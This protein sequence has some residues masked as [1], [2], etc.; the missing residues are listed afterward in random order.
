[1]P[2]CCGGKTEPHAPRA[3]L[4][5]ACHLFRPDPSLWETTVPLETSCASCHSLEPLA[6][7]PTVPGTTMLLL[8]LPPRQEQPSSH[9]PVAADTAACLEHSCAAR[10]QPLWGT[11]ALPHCL[12]RLFGKFGKS[13]CCMCP[14]GVGGVGRE[15]EGGGVGGGR[16]G[17]V[18]FC[19]ACPRAVFLPAAFCR[20]C[21]CILFCL[22]SIIRLVGFCKFYFY[23]E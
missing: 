13:P 22:N 7:L 3:E 10:A 21:V 4:F 14:C 9:L 15:G 6:R 19:P 18:P 5:A 1:M 2:P 8:T 11:R 16:G 23:S 17:V 12:L 20:H